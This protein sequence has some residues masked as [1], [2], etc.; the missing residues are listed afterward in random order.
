MQLEAPVPDKGTR[1]GMLRQV[2]RQN[3]RRAALAHRQDDA[4]LSSMNGLGG[5][6]D[7]VED[8]DAPGILHAHLRA[9]FAQLARGLDIHEEGV[10]HHLYRLAM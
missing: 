8:L 10:H 4:A 2:N 5:P 3:E 9:C 6:V 7:R 1:P